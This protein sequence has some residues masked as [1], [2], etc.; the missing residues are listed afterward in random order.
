MWKSCHIQ[1]SREADEAATLSY[2]TWMSL[3]VMSHMD[4]SCLI[5]TNHTTYKRGMS[6]VGRSC[7]SMSHVTHMWVYASISHVTYGSIVPHMNQSCRIQTSHLDKHTKLLL[8]HVTYEVVNK[9]YH[10]WM[11]YISYQSIMPHKKRWTK[12]LI[13]EPCHKWISQWI[14][15]HMEQSYDTNESYQTRIL[16]WVIRKGELRKLLIWH[17]TYEWVNESCHIWIRHITRMSH[18]R[19]ASWSEWSWTVDEDSYYF[20]TAH[21]NESMSHVTYEW[22]VS[23]EW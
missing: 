8:W 15:S 21:M 22:V 13:N 19:Y 4:E 17:S 1:T 10:P 2:H 3:W 20:G 5:W 12:L 23:H 11:S 9:V 18:I 14:M 6:R 7:Y 16:K